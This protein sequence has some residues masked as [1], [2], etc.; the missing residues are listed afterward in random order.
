MTCRSQG[1]ARRSG[2]LLIYF[3][4]KIDFVHTFGTFAILGR[5]AI[6]KKTSDSGKKSVWVLLQ[7]VGIMQHQAETAKIIPLI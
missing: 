2:I 3:Q 1:V 4:K 6:W 7:H 5:N